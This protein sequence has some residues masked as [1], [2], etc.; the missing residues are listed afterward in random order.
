VL[1]EFKDGYYK[2]R[3]VGTNDT[4]EFPKSF[5]RKDESSS[6]KQMRISVVQ[7]INNALKDSHDPRVC[8]TGF[9]NLDFRE[10]I[11]KSIPFGEIVST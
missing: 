5:V 7:A 3:I 9:S 1:E 11:S 2:G 8:I 4:G 6:A 10:A